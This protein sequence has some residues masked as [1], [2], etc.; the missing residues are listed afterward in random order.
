MRDPRGNGRTMRTSLWAAVLLCACSSPRIVDDD[1]STGEPTDESGGDDDGV[2]PDGLYVDCAMLGP[3]EPTVGPGDPGP[4]G[5]PIYACNP[6]SSGVS[7]GGHRC[8]STDPATGD[9]A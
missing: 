8:C 9:G 6:R 5:F 4:L 3:D 7:D 1:G 2:E